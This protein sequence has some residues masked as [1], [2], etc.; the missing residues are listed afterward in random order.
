VLLLC[1]R[2]KLFS[3]NFGK[4]RVGKQVAT[5]A[6]DGVDRA[7]VTV[8]RSENIR[9]LTDELRDHMQTITSAPRESS[10]DPDLRSLRQASPAGWAQSFSTI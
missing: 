1:S 8:D 10:T 7:A 9:T 6:A 5:V 3:V 4:Q 2:D